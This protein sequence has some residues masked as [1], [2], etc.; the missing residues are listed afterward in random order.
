MYSVCLQTGYSLL[1]VNV[2]EATPNAVF[3]VSSGFRLAANQVASSGG[4]PGFVCLFPSLLA[5]SR[6]VEFVLPSS[7][8][9]LEVTDAGEPKQ[10]FQI[11]S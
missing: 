10:A 5:I 3:Q 11:V 4:R 1:F 9:A 2:D 7:Y 6:S 8:L